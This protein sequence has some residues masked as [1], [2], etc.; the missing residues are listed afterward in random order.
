MNYHVLFL[1][2][3]TFTCSYTY[4]ADKITHHPKPVSPPVH[5]LKARHDK[6]RLK[7]ETG[8]SAEK[9]VRKA[10]RYAGHVSSEKRDDFI[11]EFLYNNAK[12]KKR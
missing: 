12:S 5:H 8:W 6:N 1:V 9:T 7:K 2:G 10:E 4:S 11:Q 3:I